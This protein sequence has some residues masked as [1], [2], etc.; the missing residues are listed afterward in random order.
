MT[1]LHQQ[2]ADIET[3]IDILSDAAQQCRKSMVV[4]KAAIGL[5]AFLLVAASLGLIRS[6]AIILV[7]GIAATLAGIVFYGSSR[8]SL[9]E[10]AV[11]I[12]AHEGRRAAMIDRIDLRTVSDEI[13]PHAD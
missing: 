10:I 5:G 13:R 9:E 1:D 11:K 8:S 2:I 7:L 3:E 6:D 4:A 12:R